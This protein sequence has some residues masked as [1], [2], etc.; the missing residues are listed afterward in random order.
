MAGSRSAR[1]VDHGDG[2]YSATVTA[3]T[4]SGS[5]TVTAS[6]GAL[7]D[8]RALRQLP[9]PVASVAL[10]LGSASLT[11]DGSAATTATATVSDAFGNG[12]PG[13][14][15]TIVGSGGQSVGAVV[16]HGDGTYGA[17]VTASTRSGSFTVTASA[18]ARSDAATLTQTPG[19]PTSVA[20]TLADETL[21]A[22]GTATTTATATVTDAF[23]NGVPGDDVTITSA[24]GPVLGPVTDVGD[25]S[26]TATVTASTSAGSFMIEAADGALDADPATLRQL[27]GP[28]TR[29][30]LTLAEPE[31]LV[32]AG[33]TVATATLAD[34]FGNPI[35]G[36]DLTIASD[37]GQQLGTVADTGDG[38][39]TATVAA[40]TRAGRSTLTA[41]AGSLRATAELT[42]RADSASAVVATLAPD[43][44]VADGTATTTATARV[45]DRYGNV[46]PLGGIAFR[47]DG[48]QQ[49]GPVTD[50]ADGRSTA[51]ITAATRPGRTYVVAQY[52][53]LLGGAWLTEVAGPAAIVQVT[54]DDDALVADGSAS[55]TATA[56]VTDAYGNAVAGGDEVVF[57]G[58]GGQAI[59]PVTDHGDGVYSATVTTTTRAG[60]YAISATDRSGAAPVHG[61]AQLT[62]LAGPAARLALTL[63]PAAIVADGAATT[64]ATV[65]VSDAHGNRRPDGGERIALSAPGG[66]PIGAA[67]RPRRRQLQRARHRD[68]RARPLRRPRDRRRLRGAGDCRGRADAG[69]AG[70]GGRQTADGRRP[71]LRAEQRQSRPRR[72]PHARAPDGEQRR[73]ADRAPGGPRRRP[74]HARRDG[75]SARGGESARQR[76]R[77]PGRRHP[78]RAARHARRNRPPRRQADQTRQSAR[79]PRSAR[80]AADGEADL[81]PRRRRHDGSDHAAP[82]AA[83]ERAPGALVA[84][85]A[86]TATNRCSIVTLSTIN[87]GDNPDHH[88]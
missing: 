84:P 10:A 57:A 17:T 37:G 85:G 14:T 33:A 44:L 65:V 26:Y 22:N 81:P 32:G 24:A 1:S 38:S 11:A 3:S 60:A 15:V 18:G 35:G 59:G 23:G 2:T 27:A 4:R 8:G 36:A 74:P 64:T 31:L 87:G 21:V 72:T 40:T 19:A 56:T 6:A 13:E 16:D 55:T 63:A 47:T 62:Q 41:S 28:A 75:E 51:T 68:D 77:P 12:V 48:G 79:P 71:A 52:G 34:A 43:T 53:G 58:D 83:G 7:S 80:A 76:R 49:I 67:R 45:T 50:H 39:Y 61:A 29:L 42:Q 46:L 78:R 69:G 82:G 54:L 86:H 88:P 66:Q 25:G 9:G 5:F 70:A 20:L 73:P 30:G